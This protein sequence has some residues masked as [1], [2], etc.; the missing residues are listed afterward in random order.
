[1]ESFYKDLG[2]LFN[3]SSKPHGE[4]N[5]LPPLSLYYHPQKVMYKNYFAVVVMLT[6][7]NAIFKPNL[8]LALLSIL[9]GCYGVVSIVL[10]LNDRRNNHASR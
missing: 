7:A 9:T 4:G 3:P 8:F 10:E 1:M 5:R 2:H 6:L